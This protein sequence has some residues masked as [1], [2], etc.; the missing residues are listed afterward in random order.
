MFRETESF[1]E[2]DTGF[3]TLTH[4]SEPRE[5]PLTEFVR[6]KLREWV[7]SGRDQNEL[8]R[9]TGLSPSS[10]SQVKG[11]NGVGKRSVKG[12]AHALGYGSEEELRD[13][14]YAWYVAQ[15]K[16]GID[17]AEEPEVK[18]AIATVI[19]MGGGS[20]LG[21][22]ETEVRAILHSFS[23]PRFSGRDEAYW[24]PIL[25]QELQIN[26]T[27]RGLAR[28]VANNEKAAKRKRAVTIRSAFKQALDKKRERADIDDVE[29]KEDANIAAREAKNAPPTK[30]K[31]A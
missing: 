1:S 27:L 14:A 30:Q 8:A 10:V 4:V 29:A 13:A 28:N 21:V 2:T 26:R 18:A 22:T 19:S 12:W 11:K 3:A 25:L 16:K 24:V 15:G 23:D 31:P 20:L 5:D 17:L 7:A 6:L 9:R